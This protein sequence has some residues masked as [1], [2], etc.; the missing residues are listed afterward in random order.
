MREQIEPIIREQM[1]NV[2]FVAGKDGIESF[3]LDA[4]N[5]V[6]E[7]ITEK[8]EK[9]GYSALDID[10]DYATFSEG[11]AWAKQEILALLK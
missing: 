9:V 7:A 11:F 2:W 1:E 6:I 8:I 5:G 4:T 3:I 10:P